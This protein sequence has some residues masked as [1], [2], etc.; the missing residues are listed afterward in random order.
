MHN[1]LSDLP[2]L[3]HPA[4]P[5]PT[6]K[7]SVMA[8]YQPLFDFLSDSTHSDRNSVS[9]MS[10]VSSVSTEILPSQSPSPI[11]HEGHDLLT[12]IRAAISSSK[13]F[14]GFVV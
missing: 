12:V 13:G 8:Q 11:R 9:D 7:P 10:D 1:L 3:Q 14:Q 6:S 5:T 2:S 4:S